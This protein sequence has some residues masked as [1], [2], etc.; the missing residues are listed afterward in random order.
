MDRREWPFKSRK[1]GDISEEPVLR[2]AKMANLIDALVAGQQLG[3]SET[4][5][6]FILDYAVL[7]L[8]CRAN[9][10]SRVVDEGLETKIGERD[11]L[12]AECGFTFDDLVAFARVLSERTS[13]A[14]EV[15][16]WT[17]IF[18]RL[19]TRAA[20]DCMGIAIAA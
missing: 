20:Q 13:N 14:E 19:R 9:Y 16:R 5:R 4:Q 15:Q 3:I 6:A 2:S 17:G 7:V 11:K 8:Q 10:F 12:G 1:I 18:E